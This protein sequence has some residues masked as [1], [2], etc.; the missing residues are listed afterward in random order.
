[1]SHELYRLC[2]PPPEAVLKS[3][4]SSLRFAPQLLAQRLRPSPAS[5]RSRSQPHGLLAADALAI[6]VD[7]VHGALILAVRVWGGP[8][9][10]DGVWRGELSCVSC[11]RKM[12]HGH[13]RV[14]DR[15]PPASVLLEV[16]KMT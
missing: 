3:H 1:M 16:H 6:H 2:T 13:V 5:A 7:P 12:Y 10:R 15:Q 4:P 14:W 11:R 8:I 9:P